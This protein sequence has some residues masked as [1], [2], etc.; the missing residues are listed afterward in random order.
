MNPFFFL[1]LPGGNAMF[2]FQS[3]NATQGVKYIRNVIFYR[4][5]TPGFYFLVFLREIYF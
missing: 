5:M 2:V 3:G 4:V 1:S